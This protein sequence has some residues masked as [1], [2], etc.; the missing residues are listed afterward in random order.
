MYNSVTQFLLSYK[1]DRSTATRVAQL[2]GLC[3]LDCCCQY[4]NTSLKSL[5]AVSSP[6]HPCVADTAFSPANLTCSVRPD[7]ASFLCSDD[8]ML[9]WLAAPDGECSR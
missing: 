1:L 9:A 2:A 5:K 4:V 7:I 3:G 6:P 8:G